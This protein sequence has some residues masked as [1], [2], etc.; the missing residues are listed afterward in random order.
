M[1]RKE[2]MFLG[3]D[4]SSVRIVDSENFSKTRVFGFF[5][6]FH[7]TLDCGIAS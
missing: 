7:T 3:Y 4:Y 5:I 6:H 2:I 1:G